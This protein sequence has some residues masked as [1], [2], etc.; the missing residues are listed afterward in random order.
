MLQ[1]TE[2]ESMHRREVPVDSWI[3]EPTRLAR[4][5]ANPTQKPDRSNSHDMFGSLDVR[6]TP[7]VATYRY[8]AASYCFA[9]SG[10]KNA[11]GVVGLRIPESAMVR[12]DRKLD[13][14]GKR[15]VLR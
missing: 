11:I 10:G 4:I 3:Q 1:P 12:V 5:S 6:L 15:S 14:S 7:N 2:I 9:I 8:R 13:G